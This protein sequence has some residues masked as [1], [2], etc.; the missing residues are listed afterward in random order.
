MS[1]S[2][3]GNSPSTI[4]ELIGYLEQIAQRDPAAV[5]TTRVGTFNMEP[6]VEPKFEEIAAMVRLNGGTVAYT[7]SLEEDRIHWNGLTIQANNSLTAWFL[8]SVLF[9][10]R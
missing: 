9:E 8:R 10:D 2:T 3:E 6:E 5:A 7:R 1:D 4:E